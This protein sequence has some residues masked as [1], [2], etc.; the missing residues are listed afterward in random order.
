MG[1]KGYIFGLVLCVAV[2]VTAEVK[3]LDYIHETFNKAE[4]RMHKEKMT[5]T[6]YQKA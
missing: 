2:A 1:I 4:E 5:K 6:E 3:G